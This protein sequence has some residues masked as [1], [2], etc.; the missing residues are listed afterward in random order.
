MTQLPLRHAA[1]NTNNTDPPMTNDALREKIVAEC[2]NQIRESWLDDEAAGDL[3][4]QMNADIKRVFTD[5]K[6]NRLRA[7]GTESEIAD[8]IPT[9]FTEQLRKIGYFGHR[10]QRETLVALLGIGP[11]NGRN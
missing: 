6:L 11:T 3:K 9:V 7:M 5:E 4:T 10:A 1:Q 8:S 2:F